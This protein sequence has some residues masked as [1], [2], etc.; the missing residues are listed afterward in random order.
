MVSNLLNERQFLNIP[1]ITFRTVQTVHT[2]RVTYL[3]GF[4]G[5]QEHMHM[6]VAWALYVHWARILYINGDHPRSHHHAHSKIKQAQGSHA[7]NT[8]SQDL[9]WTRSKTY[10]Q[11]SQGLDRIKHD[12]FTYLPRILSG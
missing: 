11:R 7:T 8:H 5:S 3:E 10:S 4:T 12:R 2:A 9:T 1:E 6:H